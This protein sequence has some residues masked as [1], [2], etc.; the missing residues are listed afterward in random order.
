MVRL[1]VV[2]VFALSVPARADGLDDAAAD[3]VKRFAAELDCANAS[4]D[5]LRAWCAVLTIGKERYAPPPDVTTFVGVSV[6]LRVGAKVR[7]ALLDSVTLS[8]LHLGPKSARVTSVRP[9]SEAEKQDLA[10]V[11]FSVA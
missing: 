6:A 8:A 7:Q 2:L 10:K 1:A 4:K 5:P 11:V 3:V 9:S